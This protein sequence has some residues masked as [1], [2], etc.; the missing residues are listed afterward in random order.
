MTIH[1]PNHGAVA[2]VRETLSQYLQSHWPNHP[3]GN[4]PILWQNMPIDAQTIKDGYLRFVVAVSRMAPLDLGG[5]TQSMTGVLRITLG[6]RSGL[7]MAKI[8]D[9]MDIIIGLFGTKQ[10]GAIRLGA[11]RF[12][13]GGEEN[14]FHLHRLSIGF[15]MINPS[16]HFAQ[17]PEERD[18]HDRL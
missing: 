16:T 13:Q 1:W 17:S 10:I 18:N 4:W 2:K 12:D 11:I 15:T 5:K 3:E 6:I 9:A 7:G 8:D 14:S